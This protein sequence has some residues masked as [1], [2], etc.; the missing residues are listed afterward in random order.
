MKSSPAWL[1]LPQQDTRIPHIPRLGAPATQS[2]DV[3]SSGS[4]TLTPAVLIP[5]QGVQSMMTAEM[6]LAEPLLKDFFSQGDID[7]GFLDTQMQDS[8]FKASSF[9]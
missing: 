3:A 6:A 4:G 1:S 8:R 9:L 7:L 5:S 2:Q